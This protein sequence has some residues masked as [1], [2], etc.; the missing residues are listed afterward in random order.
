MSDLTPIVLLIGLGV[1]ASFEGLALGIERDQG[2][3]LILGTAI[4]LHKGAASMSLGISMVKTFPKRRRFIQTMICLFSMFTPIGIILGMILQNTSEIV[5]I[6]FS[7]LAAGSFLYI[8][9][10]EVIVEEFLVPDNKFIKLVF[11]LI[12]IAIIA[13]LNVFEAA[14]N[15]EGI[16]TNSG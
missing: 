11:F 1:H 15:N 9:C 12:G 3:S 6:V 2:K 13:S 14:T 16:L 5:E 4:F 7:C 10:S 8:A